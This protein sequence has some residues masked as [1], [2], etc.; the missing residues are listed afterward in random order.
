MDKRAFLKTAAVGAMSSLIAPRLIAATAP[1]DTRRAA[2]AEW[3]L[4]IA[5]MESCSCRVFCQCFFT[6][7][8][9]PPDAHADH[10]PVAEHAC[11]FNQAYRVVKGHYRNL[12]LDGAQFWYTGDAGPDLHE[13]K[14]PWAVMTFD[15]AL[16]QPKRD[17]LWTMLQKL[18]FY[19]A[20]RWR[21][22]SIATAAPITW[23]HTDDGA[24]ATLDAGAGAELSLKRLKGQHAGAVVLQN[25]SYFGY[26]RNDGFALMPSVV[27]AY[28]TGSRRFEFSGTNGFVT[29]LQM[30]ADDFPAPAK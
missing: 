8:P 14:W 22:Q 13:A 4:E 15:S 18:R 1:S 23:A 26:P 30:T 12:S 2:D 16:V 7:L 19:R 11:L 10:S 17:A 5:V 24:R 25:L 28:R 29:T 20:E 21:E 27:Q 9:L 6:S 3:S